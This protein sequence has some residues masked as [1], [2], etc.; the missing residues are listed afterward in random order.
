MTL[1]LYPG[2]W[3]P[4]HLG[5]LSI[6]HYLEDKYKEQVL[7]ELCTHP[8]D[9]APLTSEEV[10]K[11]TNQ[12]FLLGRRIF[13]SI[14]TSFLAKA[15]DKNFYLQH[16]HVNETKYFI[17]GYD[18]IKRIDDKKYYFNS[19]VEKI[20]CLDIISRDRWKFIVMPRNGKCDEDLSDRI[21]EMC[22]FERDYVGPDISSTEIRNRQINSIE[23][24]IPLSEIYMSE[25]FEYK[26]NVYKHCGYTEEG[27]GYVIATIQ[28]EEFFELAPTTP[29]IKL[30][31]WFK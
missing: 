1:Y 13:T 5:H 20:R 17:V 27:D 18:T 16:S 8:Y 10:S 7:F 2:S 26:G 29:V 23:N 24:Y 31:S 25:Y 6:V 22:I 28:G 14:H 9:K 4:L 15:I 3:N 11:R 30:E 12:F 19:E 21:K